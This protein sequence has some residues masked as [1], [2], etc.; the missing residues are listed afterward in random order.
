MVKALSSMRV[1]AIGLVQRRCLWATTFWPLRR[2]PETPRQTVFT[3]S[4][5]TAGS[6]LPDLVRHYPCAW[7]LLDTILPIG[8]SGR[9]NVFLAG[10]HFNGAVHAAAGHHAVPGQLPPTARVLAFVSI[11]L[12]PTIVFYLLAERQIIAGPTAGAVKG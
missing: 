8:Y 6:V 5:G 11:A 1:R 12:M 7:A 9:G 2:A 4:M 3:C 10:S